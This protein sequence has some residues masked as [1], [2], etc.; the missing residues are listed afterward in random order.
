MSGVRTVVAIALPRR[1]VRAAPL[2]LL[3]AC[4]DFAE[5]DIP[6]R[7]AVAVLQVN[8]RAFDAG[9]FQVD[10][11]LLPGR[12]TTGFQR[13]VQSPF[14]LAGGFLVEP[15][16]LGERGLRTYSSTFQIARNATAGPFDLVPPDVRD[17]GTLPPVRLGGL[18]RVDPDTLFVQPGQDVLLR[19]DTAAVRSEPAQR[20]QQWFLDIR[21]GTRVFRISSDGPPP[22]TL[23]IPSDFIPPSPDNRAVVSMIYFQTASV[24]SETG[25]YIGNIVLDVRLNWVIV[26]RTT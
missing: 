24:R 26:F 6:N 21:S 7:A 1:A 17:A 20:F 14:I 22:S 18:R 5:P 3:S 25:A 15:R 10:G 2:L 8:M 11:S 16:A 9:V 4:L 23:R 19:M 12:D 13:V